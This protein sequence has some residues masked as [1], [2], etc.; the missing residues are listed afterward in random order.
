M[1]TLITRYACVGGGAYFDANGMYNPAVWNCSWVGY[2]VDIPDQPRTRGGDLFGEPSYPCSIVLKSCV[3]SLPKGQPTSPTPQKNDHGV[4]A[5]T[6]KIAREKGAALLLDAGGL[7]VSL[8]PGGKA[9][10]ALTGLAL[11]SAAGING[12]VH[13]DLSGATA[14]VAAYH[15]AAIGPEAARLETA[16]RTSFGRRAA[17]YVPYL[18]TI[19]AAGTLL[20]DGTKAFREYQQ[21]RA[22]K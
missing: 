12:A 4:K 17:S 8:L 1:Q 5:C 7:G 14:G 22:G 15:F 2:W 18:G 3:D 20:Y 21:C 9:A 16:A 6:S 10:V 13:R 19:L 11:S